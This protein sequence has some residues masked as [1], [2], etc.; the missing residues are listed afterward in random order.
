KHRREARRIV[1]PLSS[2]ELRETLKGVFR[3]AAPEIALVATACVMFLFGCAYNRRWL[4]F[5]VSLVGVTV[6]AILAG[7]VKTQAPAVLTASSIVPDAMAAFVRW[8]AILSAL[9][10]L[11]VSWAEVTR[12][13]A[14]EY[15]GCL[16]AVAAGV[17][18]VGRANDLI[19]LFLALELI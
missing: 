1:N 9:V 8:V 11:F 16:L 6:A 5:A 3:L 18:L 14:A 7:D 19:T 13:N 15:Y 2:P 17:S 12:S 4:W 10:L